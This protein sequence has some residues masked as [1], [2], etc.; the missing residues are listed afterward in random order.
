MEVTG[1]SGAPESSAGSLPQR[2][3]SRVPNWAGG[4]GAGGR[5]IPV[6]VS[7]ALVGAALVVAVVALT[8]IGFILAMTARTE[9][10]TAL[11]LIFRPRVGELL[12]N[13]LLLEALTL[14]ISASLAIALAWLV[15]RTDLLNARLWGWVAVAPLAVPAFV[16]SY[17]WTTVLPSLSGLWAAVL[18][19]VL[20]YTPFFVLPVSAQLRALDPGLEDAAASLGHRPRDVFVR[21]VLPQLRLSLCGGAL[22]V[23]LHLLAEYGL[24]G[25]I[26][27][28]T[29]T[30]AIMDQF[31][32]ADEGPAAN[33]LAVVL[34]AASLGLMSAFGSLAGNERY[35][36]LGRGAPRRRAKAELG[37]WRWPAMAGL[38]L[39]AVLS[40]GV[41]AAVILRWLING[42]IAAWANPDLAASLIA[43]AALAVAGALVTTFVALPM[44]WIAVRWPTRLASA[45]ET[46]HM[47]VGSLPGVVVAL[48]LVTVTVHALKPLYQ[49][50]AGLLIAFALLFLPRALASLKASFAQVPVELE[51]AAA[52]LGR[53]PL[54]TLRDV[55]LR[56]AAPGIA[57]S[58]ALAALGIGTELTATLMLAPSGLRTLSTEFWARTS[59]LDYAA[60]APAAVLMVA[61]SLPLT[62]LLKIQ[63]ERV[64]GR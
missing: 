41:P 35:A 57:A 56:L 53:P 51:D 55:T 20:A 29:F 34:I 50:L 16:H 17:A 32:S 42:G 6:T 15:E 45:L 40:L 49:S 30:T 3:A 14:P 63:S 37:A 2:V 24:Y 10:S 48:A 43:T 21:V 44:A 7:P 31:Q 58:A 4:V 9:P 46:I 13:T 36:R 12:F 61:L 59:E 23:G 39:L 5:N 47:Y 22:L 38:V 33:M 28:D 62:V 19:S 64:A 1:T 8:P 11:S 27:F 26:R 18:V 60:A 25:M 52:A 54:E